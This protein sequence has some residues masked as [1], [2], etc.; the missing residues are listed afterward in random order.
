MYHRRGFTIIELIIVATFASLLFILFFIQKSNVDAIN[1]DADRKTAI[2]AM[3]YALEESFYKDHGY[4][5]EQIS[6]DNI[7]VIDPALWTDPLGFNLGDSL[8]SYHYDPANCSDGKCK[9]YILRAD[10]EKE[11]AFVKTNRTH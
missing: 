4:Y 1:R 9:E 8:S 6:E 10:L 7:T 3:Y 11:S 5:P 2:N